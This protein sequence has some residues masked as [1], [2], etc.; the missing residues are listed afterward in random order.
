MRQTLW[1]NLLL[2]M[3][4]LTVY[5]PVRTFDYI[6]YDD[7]QYV[8]NN[9]Q[10]MSGFNADSVRWALTSQISGEWQPVTMW[11]HMIDVE[12]FGD[13]PGGHHLVNVLLH[14]VNVL[15]L[16]GV[17]RMLTGQTIAS[18]VVALLFA[19]HP[20]NV[21]TVAWISQRKS[22]LSG[23]FWL[24]SMGVYVSYRRTG[25]TSRYLLLLGLYCLGLMSKP[26]VVVL[27]CAFLLLDVWPLHRPLGWQLV[28][29]KLPLFV[30]SAIV[31]CIT[32]VVQRESLKTVQEFALLMR[33]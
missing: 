9:P 2:I 14:G 6:H 16:F 25:K 15:L 33:I 8:F 28:V 19:L 26:I 17:L 10:V 23:M 5:W 18:A 22:L 24:A 20:L 4:T 12:M 21:E 32:L 30:L 13:W 31:S 11:S 27:P 1:I 3:V 7:P 29:Q